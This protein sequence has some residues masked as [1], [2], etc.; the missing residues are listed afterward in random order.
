MHEPDPRV[1]LRWLTGYDPMLWH[2]RLFDE[3]LEGRLRDGIDA[4]TGLAKTNIIPIWLLAL[5]EGV[6][7]GSTLLPRRLIY[8]VNRRTVID[9]ATQGVIRILGALE[10]ADAPHDVVV[11][12]D[13][14]RSISTM[15]GKCLSI[16]T[17]RGEHV[18]NREWQADPAKASVVVGTVDMVGSKVLFSGYGSSWRLRAHE[19][20][21]IGCD[22]LLVHDEAPL[23]P[24]FGELLK[25]VT[26]TQTAQGT[27]RPMHVIAMSAALKGGADVFRL[28]V[29]EMGEEVVRQRVQA[30]KSLRIVQA[31]DVVEGII[32]NA[33]DYKDARVRHLIYVSSPETA[34]K[35][36][37]TLRDKLKGSACG[38]GLLTGTMR[39][40]E[41]TL[42]EKGSL[43][44]TFMAGDDRTPPEAT[45]YLVATSAGE[46]G[47]DFDGDHATFDESTMDSV[48]QR[49]GRVNRRGQGDAKVT[50][51]QDED[52]EKA[53]P[54]IVATV[55]ALNRLPKKDGDF[56]DVSPAALTDLLL[57]DSVKNATYRPAPRTLPLTD[58]GLDCL[59]LTTIRGPLPARPMIDRLLHGIEGD[60]P[61]TTVVWRAE[62]TSLITL[63]RQGRQ[64]DV[65]EWLRSHPV[66]GN[67]EQL[68]DVSRRVLKKLRA[69]DPKTD[70]LIIDEDDTLKASTIGEIAPWDIWG[71]TI[72]L[73]CEAGGLDEHGMLNPTAKFRVSDVA[74]VLRNR[75][76]VEVTLRGSTWKACDVGS[77]EQT[78]GTAPS[79]EEALK[80]VVEALGFPDFVE[81][82]RLVLELDEEGQDTRLLVS[83]GPARSIEAALRQ[84]AEA[85]ETQTLD[86]HHGW[87]KGFAERIT[88]RLGVPA[89]IASAVVLAAWIHDRGKARI[90]W[91]WAI[92]NRKNVAEPLAKSGHGR[93]RHEL[94]AG[95]RHEFGTLVDV[96]QP[97]MGDPILVEVL[98]HPE[99]ELVLHLVAMHHGRAR[100]HFPRSAYDPEATTALNDR[101]AAEV[102]VR[103]ASLQRRFGH[104]GLAWIETLMRTSDVLASIHGVAVEGL[105]L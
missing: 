22:S 69:L 78:E 76:R 45:Q 54:E 97:D 33:L 63:V 58:I 44:Q 10:H 15:P 66:R 25:T 28:T 48:V 64:E 73:P 30:R 4:P 31:P 5:A 14:L 102:P 34:I 13:T 8:V 87:T 51:I 59:S 38:V 101:I 61:E 50:I 77:P 19:A 103:F 43:V 35:V 41:R 1:V 65:A 84:S 104:W 96:A 99:R 27:M 89:A 52:L 95:Y 21:T 60:P 75:V 88:R 91:Q 3:M 93:F 94:C 80:I 90:V 24:S 92:G 68:G 36:A 2:L 81:R 82:G 57:D 37:T 72:L 46:Y 49:T 53:S 29:D 70:V 105:P 85:P 6:R 18:D 100:P 55:A 74:D 40:R 26:E 16:S 20:G 32:K 9:Q 62:V 56:L 98:N 67:S 83:L 47:V 86:L 11:V 7:R 17:L 23:S 79:V 42:L 39:S 71:A 12:R